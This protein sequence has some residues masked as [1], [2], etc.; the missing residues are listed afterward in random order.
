M[1]V[2]AENLSVVRSRIARAAELAGREPSSIRLVA[3][4]KLMPSEAIR[5]AYAA[6]QRDFGENYVQELVRK[7]EE[8]QDLPELR[9]HLIGHLQTNKVKAVVG[10]VSM[11][12][13][14]SSVRLVSELEKRL[15]VLP[16]THGTRWPA[17]F[18]SERNAS[19]TRL[20]ILVEVNVG[21]EAQKSGCAPAE[22][23]A[24]LEAI[25]GSPHLCA[26]GLM[27]VPPFDLDPQQ[28]RPH[29]DRL[30]LLRDELGGVGRL[31]EL[32]MGMTLDLEEAILAGATLVRVGT[33]IFGER[34]RREAP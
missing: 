14:V 31:P 15:S 7:A 18:P 2:I 9:L 8:L 30:R 11:I 12:Q 29:F 10:S 3:V 32:S 4:S 33:A 23:N 19:Q 24:I 17:P 1:S 25:E 6:G 22:A 21:G 16:K 5:E 20:P 13:S 34:P 28:A 27:T 26:H